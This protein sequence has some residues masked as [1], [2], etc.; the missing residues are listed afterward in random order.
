ME[1][2]RTELPIPPL[3]ERASTEERVAAALRDLIVSGR[4]PEGTP[5]VHREVASRLGVSP[6]PVR[7]GL[8]QL[9][10][11]GLVVVGRSGRAHVS[12]L[13]REDFEEIYAARLGL[14]GLAAR[15]GAPRVRDDALRTMAAILERL[16][17]LA[18]RQDVDEYL[19]LRWDFHAACY[20]ASG[21]PRLVAEVER[22]Y[23]RSERYNRL[24]LASPGR[25][26][27]SVAR[28]GTFLE[29]CRSR[30]GDAAEQIIHQA[31][32]WAM[33]RLAPTLPSEEERP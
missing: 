33:D 19:R 27:A 1:A 4:L 6:T 11:E 22:L 23:R 8:S 25:F 21:R 2:E 12:H 16:R 13:T 15:L 20:R 18:E 9:E 17:A 24:V 14:E 7:A 5:L 26:R 29:A 3:E 28:Y 30:D 10:R 31:M 32:R